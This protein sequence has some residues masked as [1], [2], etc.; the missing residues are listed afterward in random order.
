M[1]IVRDFFQELIPPGIEPVVFAVQFFF[2]VVAASIV[3]AQDVSS[4]NELSSRS[5]S[6]FDLW[7]FIKDNF[8]RVVAGAGVMWMLLYFTDLFIPSDSPKMFRYLASA[9]VGA[10]SDF[11]WK[12]ALR[13]AKSTISKKFE[14]AGQ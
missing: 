3:L 11:I 1:N 9:I 12:R 2:A 7:F 8:L 4:R 14:K 10:F 13:W 6:K 5:P